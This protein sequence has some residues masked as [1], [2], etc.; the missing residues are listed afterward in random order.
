M[1]SHYRDLRFHTT[2][3]YVFSPLKSMVSYHRDLGFHTITCGLE[4]DLRL[5]QGLLHEKRQ[6]QWTKSLGQL[7][8]RF[9]I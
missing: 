2:G 6:V 7:V 9:L 5:V 4:P 8:E 1:A 3:I